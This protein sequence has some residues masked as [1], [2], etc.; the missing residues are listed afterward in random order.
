MITSEQNFRTKDRKAEMLYVLIEAERARTKKLQREEGLRALESGSLSEDGGGWEAQ[1]PSTAEPASSL[2]QAHTPDSEWFPLS[3]R[4]M[5]V[6][7][8][9]E[10][11]RCC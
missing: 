2:S 10:R 3:P 5:C 7:S 1:Q 8:F 6:F 9:Y 4:E 11:V